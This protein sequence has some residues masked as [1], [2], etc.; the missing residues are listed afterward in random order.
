VTLSDK[1]I[2]FVQMNRRQ[3]D[4]IENGQV[5]T[6][7]KHFGVLKH[8]IVI[9]IAPGTKAPNPSEPSDKISD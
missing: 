4:Q 7:V 1:I 6:I 5:L 8:S 3:I 9:D 2:E